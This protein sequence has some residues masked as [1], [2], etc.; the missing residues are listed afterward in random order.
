M[1]SSPAWRELRGKL[2]RGRRELRRRSL[3]P[4]LVGQPTL[5]DIV[6]RGHLVS[7]EPHDARFFVDPGDRVVGAWLMQRGGS[8]RREI[9]RAVAL[10]AAA[11]RIAADAVF[12]DVV[13]ISVRRR[14]MRRTAAASAA[15]SPSSP[16][17]TTPS[18]WQ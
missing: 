7:C 17:H 12:V 15:L 1:V 16:T 5:R 18:C 8:Q 11:G 14:I 10:L 13:P 4:L 3:E 9:Q 2:S 6:M